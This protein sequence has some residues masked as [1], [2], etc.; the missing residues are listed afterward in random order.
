MG[1]KTVCAQTTLR[2]IFV[3]LARFMFVYR[4]L[5]EVFLLSPNL[6]SQHAL[7]VY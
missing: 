1:Q 3:P 2:T 6:L 7:I 5:N 4:G